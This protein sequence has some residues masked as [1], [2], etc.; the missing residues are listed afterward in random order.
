MKD[1]IVRA[2]NFVRD[3]NHGFATVGGLIVG[4][5][6]AYRYLSN[7]PIDT[8]CLRLTIEQTKMLLEDRHS[9]IE[10]ELP[11]QLIHVYVDHTS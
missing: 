9:C 10:Y 8:A 2:K 5:A 4:S 6:V 1:R 11:R 3:H 7:Q